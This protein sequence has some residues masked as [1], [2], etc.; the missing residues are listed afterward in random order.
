MI[1]QANKPSILIVDDTPENL[2]IL[3]NALMDEYMVRPA[4]NGVLALRLATMEPQPDI[5]LLDV[6][7][8][9]MDGYEVCRRLKLDRRTRDIPVIFVTTMSDDQDELKGLQI[10]AA[11]YITKPISIP[12]VKARIRTHLALRNVYHEMEEKNRRLHEVNDRLSDSMDQLSA[13]EE[14]FRSLVQTIPDIVYKIDAEGRFTFLNRSIERLGYRQ[15]DLIG[16]HFSEIIHSA[17]IQDASL[18]KVLEKTSQGTPNPSQKVFDERRTGL[19]MTVGLEIRLKNRIG[20]IDNIYELKNIDQPGVPVEVNSTG[21]YGECE[22]DTIN[23]TRQ[24]IGTV[25]V[26][27]DITDRMKVQNALLAERNLLRQLMDTIPLPDFFLEGESLIFANQ[28]FHNLFGTVNDS[29]A[30]GPLSSYLSADEYRQ[31]NT[32]L[33]ALSSDQEENRLHQIIRLRSCNHQQYDV[34]IRLH[35]CKRS[36]DARPAVIGVL[37]DDDT[38]KKFAIQPLN[39]K[40]IS[41]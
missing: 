31:I 13:S 1:A 4:I 5:I 18:Q 9:G 26:I 39:G 34:H 21:L 27:R 19:R 17:D 24:Y 2:D 33:S 28:S 30:A 8:P 10:G 14:R 40:V 11:D 37:V 32:L 36:A 15:S 25:G 6:L 22:R 38:Q 3:K 7:M 35:K 20:E 41:P 12:I 16:K 29:M 23:R